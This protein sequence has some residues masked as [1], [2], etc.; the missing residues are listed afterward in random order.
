MQGCDLKTYMSSFSVY[1]KKK[2]IQTIEKHFLLTVGEG[3]MINVIRI[4]ITYIHTYISQNPYIHLS[5][6]PRT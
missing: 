3:E 5:T 4:G 6:Y 2:K 1:S